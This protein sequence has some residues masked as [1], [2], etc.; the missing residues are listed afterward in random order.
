MFMSSSTGC[1]MI[2]WTLEARI[3]IQIVASFRRAFAITGVSVWR[4]Q[5]RKLTE[6]GHGA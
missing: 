2:S 3:E 1:W 6:R 5:M 4:N